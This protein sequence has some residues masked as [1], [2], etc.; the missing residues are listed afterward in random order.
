[1]HVEEPLGVGLAVG[2]CGVKAHGVGEGRVEDA[3]VAAG[4]LLEDGGEATALS[5]GEGFYPCDVLFGEQ[6]QLER[7]DSPEGN[8]GC[9]G[10]V[11]GDDALLLGQLEGEVGGEEL[12]IVLGVVGELGG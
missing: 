12:L 7:P 5:V 3:V 8:E 2:G 9:P 11:L 1:M 4:D 6:E 10:L